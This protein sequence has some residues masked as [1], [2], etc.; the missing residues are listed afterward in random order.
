MKSPPHRRGGTQVDDF[1]KGFSKGKL[2]KNLRRTT[3]GGSGGPRPP[4]GFTRLTQVLSSFHWFSYSN[5]SQGWGPLMFSYLCLSIDTVVRAS[6][7][8]PQKV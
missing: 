7:P 3:G 6:K 4:Y 5:Q 1:T 8:A 2:T